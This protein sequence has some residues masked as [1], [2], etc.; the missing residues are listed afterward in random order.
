[1]TDIKILG[2]AL[3]RGQ[4]A[5]AL[6]TVVVLLAV[7]CFVG[8]CSFKTKECSYGHR[9]CNGPDELEYCQSVNGDLYLIKAKCPAGYVCVD[10]PEL[11]TPICAFSGSPYPACDGV[12]SLWTCEQSTMLCCVGGYRTA[13]ITCR[14]SSQTGLENCK[15]HVGTTCSSTSDCVDGLQCV[16]TDEGKTCTTACDCPEEETCAACTDYAT[17]SLCSDGWCSRPNPYIGGC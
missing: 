4:S 3:D 9:Q 14:D 7:G 6:A 10:T 13:H 17:A 1:V 16:A 11:G 5:G 12:H 2:A 15:G 8:G